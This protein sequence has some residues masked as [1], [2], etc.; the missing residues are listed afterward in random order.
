MAETFFGLTDKGRVRENNEDAVLAQ[1]LA[2]GR[3]LAGAIDGVGGYNGGEVA[4]AIAKEVVAEQVSKAGNADWTKVLS[5][6]FIAANDRIYAEKQQRKDMADMSCVL[7]VAVIDPTQNKLWYAHVGD[8]RMYLLRDGS[9]IKISKDHSFVGFLEDSGRITEEAAMKHPKRN[10]INKALGFGGD[11][12]LQADYIETGESP[13]LPGDVL[14]FCSDGLT[15]ML[16]S[17]EIKAVLQTDESLKQKC[18]R[19]IALANEHGGKDNIT[20]VIVQHPKK[21]NSQQR[22]QAQTG[23]A[24]YRKCST[25]LG[26]TTTAGSRCL[27]T[28][29]AAE[30]PASLDEMGIDRWRI[31]ATG[32]S[33][34]VVNER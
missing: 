33:G 7:T 25:T 28:G 17:D 19:L 26:I 9:L 21:K 32:T 30:G 23:S 16:G 27:H 15:D 22:H 1:S 18:S 24:R 11:I 4:A 20:A 5:N 31:V 10:E 6:A 3:I 8:T 13:F 12:R 2:G 29:A 34:L 14:L